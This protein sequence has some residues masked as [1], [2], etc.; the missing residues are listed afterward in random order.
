[1]VVHDVAEELPAGGHLEALEALLG[2]HAVERGGGG[3]GARDGA[4][5]LGKVGDGLLGVGSNDRHAVRRVDEEAAAQNHVTI[6]QS[7]TS[8]G[9]ILPP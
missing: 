8:V 5:A 3:H 1:M 7:I 6:L 4:E 2:G 9:K